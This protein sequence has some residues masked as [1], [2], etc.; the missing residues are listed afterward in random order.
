MTTIEVNYFV[1]LLSSIYVYF[2]IPIRLN[3]LRLKFKLR[4]VLTISREM[5]AV[6]LLVTTGVPLSMIYIVIKSLSCLI[7]N[8]IKWLC[9]IIEETTGIDSKCLTDSVLSGDYK[10]EDPSEQHEEE[11]I[12]ESLMEQEADEKIESEIIVNENTDSDN[13]DEQETIK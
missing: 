5:F 1:R 4:P 6:I 12:N 10:S 3:Y 9:N 13:N 8:W 11:T 7:E 2:W